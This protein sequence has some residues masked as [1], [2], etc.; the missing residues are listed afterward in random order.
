MQA[1]ADRLPDIYE[2]GFKAYGAGDCR[3]PFKPETNE[4]NAWETGWWDGETASAN[5]WLGKSHN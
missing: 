5:Q 4:A 2:Q 1:T 3:N